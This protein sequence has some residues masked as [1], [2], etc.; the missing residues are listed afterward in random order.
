MCRTMASVWTMGESKPNS[1]YTE[2]VKSARF[3]N[4]VDR[5]HERR[6]IGGPQGLDRAKQAE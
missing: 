3:L 6:K 5:R 1:R 2:K 4:R